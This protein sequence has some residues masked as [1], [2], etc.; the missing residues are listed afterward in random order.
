MDLYENDP[1]RGQ[2]KNPNVVDPRE[3]PVRVNAN[4]R[5]ED[6]DYARGHV[7]VARPERPS[8]YTGRD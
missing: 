6:S 1:D 2:D 8:E 7:V 4:F 3:F 5:G